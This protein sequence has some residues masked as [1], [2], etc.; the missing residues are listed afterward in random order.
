M[1]PAWPRYSRRHWDDLDRLTGTDTDV[2]KTAFA[3]AVTQTLGATYWKPV[4]AGLEGESDSAA[5][6]RLGN[7]PPSTMAMARRWCSTASAS[8]LLTARPMR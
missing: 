3:A 4:Q 5:F 7:V 6:M 2:G 1:S 8:P